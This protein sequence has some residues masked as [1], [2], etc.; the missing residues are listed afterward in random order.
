M[1]E[2]SQCTWD[3]SWGAIVNQNSTP[4][5]LYSEATGGWTWEGGK[6][7][8]TCIDAPPLPT[9]AIY[10]ES[11]AECD[12][13]LEVLTIPHGVDAVSYGVGEQPPVIQMQLHRV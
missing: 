3:G 11:T 5:P 12:P 6:G 9:E 4:T 7:I 10:L 8:W 13:V 1:S 2:L